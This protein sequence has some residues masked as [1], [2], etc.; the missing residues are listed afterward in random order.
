[1]KEV[2]TIEQA[3]DGLLLKRGEA[4]VFDSP[5]ILNYAQNNKDVKMVGSLFAKQY[6]AFG[7]KKDSNLRKNINKRLL[8]IRESSKY[9]EIY[10][11]WF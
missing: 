8:V 1:M 3:Y 4:L 7:L 11:N 9:R 10:E 5:C 6:Y 2:P